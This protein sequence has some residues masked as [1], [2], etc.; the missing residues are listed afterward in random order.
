MKQYIVTYFIAISILLVR[1]FLFYSSPSP[2]R[3]GQKI[4]LQTTLLSEPVQKGSYQTFTVFA[5]GH[6]R[7]LVKTELTQKLEYGDVLLLDGVFTGSVIGGNEVLALNKPKITKVS[8]PIWLSLLHQFRQGSKQLYTH[9]LPT[10][11]A[12]LLLGIV[13]GIKSP[14]S[15]RFSSAIQ[16]VGLTH[17]SAAS[18]MN[19]TLLCG[20]LGT[21]LMFF[22]KRQKT[23]GMIVGVL[24]IYMVLS[25]LQGSILRATLMGGGAILAGI[26][27]RQ[28]QGVYLLVLTACV[29]LFISPLLLSD[30]GFQ[31]SFLSTLGILLFS[32]FVTSLTGDKILLEDLATSWCAQVLSLPLILITF[33][34]Y[35]L[36]SLVVN[37]LV[38]WV[39]APLMI[40][41]GLASILGT[42][43]PV[44]GYL[45]LVISIPLLWYFQT[46]TLYFSRFQTGLTISSFPVSLI[47]FYYCFVGVGYIC[48]KRYQDKKNDKQ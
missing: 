44:I 17:V 29:L 42:I 41:G 46:V 27:G 33:G 31:L 35:N 7:V 38:L 36:L 8:K 18:G 26:F 14:M 25:G 23:V 24:V 12:S 9:V 4:Q 11:Q 21:T 1:L 40:L 13:Y 3:V 43:V 5:K 10:D 6:Y 15:Y 20:F 48:L 28:K 19:V 45:L 32:P 47:I 16:N 2:Y 39:V 22:M 37:M 34:K 30:L